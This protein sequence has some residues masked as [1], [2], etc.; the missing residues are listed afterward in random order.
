[1]PAFSRIPVRIQQCS[2]GRRRSTSREETAGCAAVVRAGDR[3]WG[4]EWPCCGF[5]D[6]QAG[7][8]DRDTAQVPG[9]GADVPDFRLR[10]EL[11]TT[12]SHLQ[13]AENAWKSVMRCTG[14]TMPPMLPGRAWSNSSAAFERGTARSFP[15]FIIATVCQLGRGTKREQARRVV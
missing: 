13:V 11:E 5:H 2:L 15:L 8:S 14:N 3:L 12:L 6:D 1:M 9:F 7:Q 4:F 10:A